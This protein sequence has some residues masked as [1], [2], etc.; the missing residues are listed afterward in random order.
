MAR[1]ATVTAGGTVLFLIF[2]GVTAHGWNDYSGRPLGTDFSSF[3]AAGRLIALGSNPYDPSALH[4]MQRTI[5]G[6][7]T[8]YYAFAYPPI[9]LL[10]AWP[11]AQLPYLLS[12]AIWQLSSFAL[13]LWG[14]TLLKQRFAPALSRHL[15]YLGA[16][17][18]TAVFVNLTHGQNGFLTAGLY[19]AA[20]A[21]LGTCPVL[22]GLCFG[23]A[24]Y[25]PQL[26]LLVPF[27][28]AAGGHWRSFGAA[29]VTVSVLAAACSLLF[30]T[31]VWAEF[32]AG[33]GQARRVILDLDGVGYAKLVSVFAWLRLW[34]LP[35][36][37]AYAGQA[38]VAILVIAMTMR[39]WQEGDLRLKGAAMCLGVLLVTPFALDYDLMIAAPAIL[40]LASYDMERGQ[41]PFGGSLLF[42]LWFM[43]LFARSLANSMA[44]PIAS[45]TLMACFLMTQIRQQHLE[46]VV[47]RAQA[48]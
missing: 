30:G 48:G 46:P 4:D 39:S 42:L 12:L 21:S 34:H 5:F 43:P 2:L 28:L 11:L 15:F 22:A 31:Q 10:L 17:G 16:T 32:F 18:F 6:S 24:A 8:P 33:A 9:F 13:Y 7:A 19:A 1:L 37:A 41:I 25:K 3:Y 20:L 44:L 38:V 27:A 29:V 23:L 26:G 40:L 36:F 47:E 45:W 14:M 35:V